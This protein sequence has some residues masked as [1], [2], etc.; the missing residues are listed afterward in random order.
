MKFLVLMLGYL[1]VANFSGCA[2]PEEIKV[3]QA[4][5]NQM[6]TRL[7]ESKANAVVVC[8][9]KKSCDKAFSLAKVYVQENADMKIQQSDETI[10]STFNPLKSGYIGLSATKI[11]GSGETASIE[12]VATC[13]DMNI[14]FKYCAPPMAKIYE[15]FKPFIESRLK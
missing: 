12:L 8:M 10:V 9:D 2:S 7:V 4:E 14:A 1:I 6:R 5:E 3:R 11:P 15:N 13:K